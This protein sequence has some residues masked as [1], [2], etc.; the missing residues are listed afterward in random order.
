MTSWIL[1]IS[2]RLPGNQQRQQET[3][4]PCQGAAQYIALH[5][6]ASYCVVAVVFV[7]LHRE[8]EECAGLQYD[9]KDRT[10]PAHS[11][12]PMW[13]L[14]TAFWAR[15]L[16][17]VFLPRNIVIKFPLGANQSAS[18]VTSSFL[19]SFKWGIMCWV[20]F[21][22]SHA[23]SFY[24]FNFT[25]LWMMHWRVPSHK[26]RATLINWANAATLWKSGYFKAN[27]P[28]VSP[29]I[30]TTYLTKKTSSVFS[31]NVEIDKSQTWADV[32]YPT[33]I[34]VIKCCFEKV[35]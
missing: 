22:Q 29:N 24:S 28:L 25:K 35:V 18:L 13:D 21:E 8:M 15:A 32:T 12:T 5:T 19:E 11:G 27:R 2:E 20:P 33:E 3:S 7:K 26:N 16:C 9:H 14:M 23:S 30:K 34:I 6:T 1:V 31:T 17:Q 4:T 10:K